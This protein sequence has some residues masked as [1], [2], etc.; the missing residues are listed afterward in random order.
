M[1]TSEE[2]LNLVDASVLTA[3]SAR[4]AIDAPLT[5]QG[6]DSLDVAT[7]MTEVEA[8]YEKLISSEQ[9]SQLKTIVDIVNF[10]N[11]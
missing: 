10:L 6:L 9:I 4:L 7:L 8:K 11:A 2:I 1:I 3:R 5:A